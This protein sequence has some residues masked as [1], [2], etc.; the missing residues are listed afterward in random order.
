MLVGV[1]IPAD[2][3]EEC[4][5]RAIDVCRKFELFPDGSFVD[6]LQMPLERVRKKNG[7]YS[8]LDEIFEKPVLYSS[9]GKWSIN[10]LVNELTTEE[11]KGEKRHLSLTYRYKL[12]GKRVEFQ[13][14]HSKSYELSSEEFALSK[15]VSN[16]PIVVWKKFGDIDR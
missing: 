4:F 5:E 6:S 3:S 14:V 15:K 11:F 2:S 1:W 13:V 16:D 10:W 8:S 12:N 7:T 9:S